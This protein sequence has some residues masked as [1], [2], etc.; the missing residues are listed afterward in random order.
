[1]SDVT[2]AFPVAPGRSS[3]TLL[4]VS[5]ERS[6]NPQQCADKLSHDYAHVGVFDVRTRRPFAA[7]PV[8]DRPAQALRIAHALLLTGHDGDNPDHTLKD[9]FICYWFHPPMT[10]HGYVQGYPIQW[11]EGHLLVRVDPLW[12]H[13]TNTLIPPTDTAR[14]EHNLEQQYAFGQ[15]IFRAYLALKP[16]FPLSWHAIGPRPNDSMFY[17]QR[18]EPRR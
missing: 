2:P 8:P 4:S 16:P 6:I 13:A 7:R 12:N 18:V 10:G 14:V 5:Q 3:I 11:D 15:R 9:R 1:M 17:V